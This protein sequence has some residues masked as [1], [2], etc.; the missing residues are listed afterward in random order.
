MEQST[1]KIKEMAPEQRRE[2]NRVQK[3]Q[4]RDRER[5]E[6]AAKR[7]PNAND[8]KMADAS[9]KSLDQYS[10]EILK[11]VQAELPDHK[12]A[13]Q[14]KYVIEVTS[15]VLFGLENNIVQKVVSPHGMLV[16]GH[17]PDAVASAAIKHV[18][19]FPSLLGSATFKTMYE[20]LLRAVVAWD[21]KY[22]HRFSSPDLMGDIRSELDGTYVLKTPAVPVPATPP[23][24]AHLINVPNSCG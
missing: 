22:Q 19:R 1:M 9:Q 8:F 11:T 3:Q 20:K 21:G 10:S 6:A 15:R 16:G 5:E 24:T 12:F 17:Y 14:E 23:S 18:H 13:T 4:Q 2:Y 7:I